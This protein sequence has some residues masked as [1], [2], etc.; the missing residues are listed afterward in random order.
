MSKYEKIAKLI[1]EDLTSRSG[2]DLD[3]DEE[4]VREIIRDWALI[5]K[6]NT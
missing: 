3:L 1:F 4:I 6:E 5:I 2:L